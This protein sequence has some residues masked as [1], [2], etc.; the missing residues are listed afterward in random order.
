MK[1]YE[2]DMKKLGTLTEGAAAEGSATGEG[3]PTAVG[4]A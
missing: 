2:G 4:L 1:E 3:T